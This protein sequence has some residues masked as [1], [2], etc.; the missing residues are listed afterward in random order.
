MLDPFR[1]VVISLVVDGERESFWENFEIHYQ[2][3]LTKTSALGGNLIKRLYLQFFTASFTGN[4]ESP[5]L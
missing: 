3:P 1:L 4:S 5:N 2:L